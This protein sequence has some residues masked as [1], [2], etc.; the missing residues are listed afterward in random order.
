MIDTRC[1]RRYP[2]GVMYTPQFEISADLLR[3]VAQASEIKSWIGQAVVDVPWLPILQRDTAARLAHS[4][5]SIEG[6]PLSLP[7]VEALA[8]GEEIGAQASAKREVLNYLA[9]MRWIWAK[10]TGKPIDEAAVL[11]L[12][13][14]L[15][16]GI[17]PEEKVGHYKRRPNRVVD[18]KGRTIYTPP[19][20]KFARP[21]T[22]ELL[23]WINGNRAK[24]IHPIV[25]SA[26]AHHRLVSIH[27][28]SDGNGRAARG[29]AVWILYTR[30]FD[31]HHLFALDEFFE[32]DRARYYQNIRQARELDD[33]LTYWLEYVA[34]GVVETLNR[35]KDRIQSLRVSSAAARM[36]LTK[37]QEDVLRFLRDRGRTKLT[38]IETVFQ[39]TRARVWQIISPLVK[40]GLVCQEGRTRATTYR[41]M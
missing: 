26:V 8:R 35:T 12:H 39:I 24:S 22:C 28:F 27:P 5:T 38:E 41:L 6:N 40:A 14:L 17:L 37:R 33:D 4:S 20:P 34:E 9:A 23:S 16:R 3:L 10:K 31:T 15:T 2:R 13:H 21:L 19:A 18:S 7:E 29:L 25:V 30:D 11:R 36:V 32:E 1:A